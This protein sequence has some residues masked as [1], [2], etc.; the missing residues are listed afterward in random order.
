MFHNHRSLNKSVIFYPPKTKKSYLQGYFY[1]WGYF[2]DLCFYQHF[3]AKPGGSVKVKNNSAIWCWTQLKCHDP[4]RGQENQLSPFH[5][6]SLFAFLPVTGPLRNASSGTAICHCLR[7]CLAAGEEP[8]LVGGV[9]VVRDLP[10]L[11]LGLGLWPGLMQE[12]LFL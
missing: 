3:F 1:W 8:A 7:S 12:V 10:G 6:S 11:L 9:T 4:S 5:W 2:P